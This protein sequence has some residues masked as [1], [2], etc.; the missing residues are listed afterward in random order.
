MINPYVPGTL[1]RYRAE[2]AADLRNGL[3]ASLRQLAEHQHACAAGTPHEQPA[4][5]LM[6]ATSAE[7]YDAAARLAENAVDALTDREVSES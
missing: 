2:L 4:T 7:A 3:I 1:E 5:R 6:Y